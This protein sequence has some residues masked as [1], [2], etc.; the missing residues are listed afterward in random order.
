MNP[1]DHA[2]VLCV[3]ETT[4]IQALEGPQPLLPWRLGYVEGVTHN[5][6]HHGRTTLFTALD[7]ATGKVLT[8]CKQRHR[9]QEFLAFLK[10]IEG[11]VPDF[12]DIPLIVDN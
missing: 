8:E 1:P 5:Y 12:L 11:N 3:D 6:I 10:H 7:V 4:Q 9:R 2:V